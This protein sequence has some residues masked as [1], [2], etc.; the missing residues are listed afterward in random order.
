MTW[1]TFLDIN[2]EIFSLPTGWAKT[3]F[4]KLVVSIVATAGVIGAYWKVLDDV[5]H[6]L[7]GSLVVPANVDASVKAWNASPHF[8]LRTAVALLCVGLV[9]AA[10]FFL[11][12]QERLDYRTRIAKTLGVRFTVVRREHDVLDTTGRCRMTSTEEL[13]VYDLHL[14][15]IERRLQ[16]TAATTRTRPLIAISGEP[17]GITY[18]TR[19]R[20]EGPSRYYVINFLPALY[21]TTSPVHLKMTEEVEKAIYMYEQDAPE[22]PVFNNS[23]V[24][25]VSFFVVEPI[26][27]LELSVTFPFDYRVGGQSQIGVRYGRTSTVHDIEE[28]RLRNSV[29]SKLGNGRQTLSLEV[30][31]PMIGLHYYLY[32][33]PPRR[34]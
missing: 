27:R 26:E 34:A 30:A 31:K 5:A 22:Q 23:R 11:A 33:V 3:T 4:W 18:N 28:Q 25:F 32:W 12:A 14:S 9:Y 15:H 21:R 17:D 1:D 7:I 16:V 24:E 8:L 2:R 13:Q 19:F 20:D 10:A 29:F 6:A